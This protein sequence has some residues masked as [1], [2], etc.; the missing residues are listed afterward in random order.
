MGAANTG[1][2]LGLVGGKLAWQIP[3]EPWS[4]LLVG[5]DR[6][7]LGKWTHVAATHDGQT[8]R[9]LVDGKL[10]GELPRVGAIRPSEA[11]LVLGSFAPGD[12]RHNFVGVIDEVKLHDRA[13]SAAEIADGVRTE[14]P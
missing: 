4:H 1:Y 5:P 2:R 11:K 13:L 10:K 12:S 14:T 9:L 8:M 6:V 3:Q 7:P